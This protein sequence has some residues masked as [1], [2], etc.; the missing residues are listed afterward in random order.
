[1]QGTGNDV[2]PDMAKLLTKLMKED[3]RCGRPEVATKMTAA[4]KRENQCKEF[5][6]MIMICDMI[7]HLKYEDAA[8]AS[9]KAWCDRNLADVKHNQSGKK[10]E[11]LKEETS[12]L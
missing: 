2:D 3:L 8:D 10:S 7:S 1:M 12:T 6:G 4:T 5:K 11:Q 9:V